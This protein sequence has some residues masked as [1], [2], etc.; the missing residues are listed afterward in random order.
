MFVDFLKFPGK[1]T[2]LDG[3]VSESMSS[4]VTPRASLL[5]VICSHTQ[6]ILAAVLGDCVVL[7][8]SLSSVFPSPKLIDTRVNIGVSKIP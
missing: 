3:R 7:F 1:A 5:L 4:A 6:S 8:V 2:L